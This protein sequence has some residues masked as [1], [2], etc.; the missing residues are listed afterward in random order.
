MGQAR[1]A[2][3]REF[4]YSL[5]MEL[6]R[7]REAAMSSFRPMLKRHG[8]TETQWRVIR[9]LADSPGLETGELAERS[10]IL[11]PSLTR[12][13]GRLEDDKLIVR[14]RDSKDRRRSFLRLSASGQRLFEAIAP[15]S[16]RLYQKIE[17]AFGKVR[18][19]ELYVLL[20]ELQASLDGDTFDSAPAN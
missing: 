13:L 14:R 1:D 15:E 3:L 8:L 17:Q 5:P 16:E 20:A 6:L 2:S 19:D 9:A 10:F 12:I 11:S 4:R 7:A 18:L